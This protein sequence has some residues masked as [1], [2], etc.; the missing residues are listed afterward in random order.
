M[1]YQ[2]VNRIIFKALSSIYLSLS[3]H[4]NNLYYS[5]SGYFMQK[6]IKELEIFCKPNYY[7]LI[8]MRSSENALIHVSVEAASL[9]SVKK[10]RHSCWQHFSSLI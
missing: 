9:I 8:S 5:L 6:N 2:N 1:Q 4:L 7:Q 10:L 3:T